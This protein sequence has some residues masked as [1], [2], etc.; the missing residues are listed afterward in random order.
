LLHSPK[1][2]FDVV[3]IDEAHQLAPADTMPTFERGRQVVVIGDPYLPA[4]AAPSLLDCCLQARLAVLPLRW[5]EPG[6]PLTP[7]ANAYFYDRGLRALPSTSPNGPPVQL[8]R[9][10]GATY[11]EVSGGNPREVQVAVD[12]LIQQYRE[13]SGKK[14]V[15]ILSFDPGHQEALALEVERRG[16]QQPELEGCLKEAVVSGT[17]ERDILI[18]SVGYARDPGGKLPTDFGPLSQEGGQRWVNAAALGAREKLLIVSSL[19]PDDLEEIEKPTTGLLSDEQSKPNPAAMVLQRDLAA[20]LQRLNYQ[21]TVADES[22]S[23]CGDLFIKEP[24]SGRPLLVVL[25]DGVGYYELVTVRDRERLL[26]EAL[27]KFGWRCHRIWGPDWWR[28]RP[29][30]I[31]RLR[32]ALEVG[33]KPLAPP[34]P[35]AKSTTPS[36]GHGQVKRLDQKGRRR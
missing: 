6:R 19:G 17:A 32:K 28:R 1:S 30:E 15:G 35:A 18:L 12:L 29:E 4:E 22:V 11:D 23:Y 13:V 24:A 34:P 27:E 16:Q 10:E 31:E 33:R 14:S 36:S 5:Q 20:E 2:M 3:V 25:C 26:P 7:F 21:V 9:V 8:N